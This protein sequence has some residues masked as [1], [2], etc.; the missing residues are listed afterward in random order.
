MIFTAQSNVLLYLWA[1]RP[2]QREHTLNLQTK[3]ELLI[4]R[5]EVQRGP[6]THLHSC[7]DDIH[8]CV[9]KH[10]GST[11]H[12][13]EQSSYHRVNVF[14]GVVA[15]TWKKRRHILLNDTK[16]ILDVWTN[17]ISSRT[18]VPVPQR[19]HD[20][21]ADGLVGALLQYS[22]CEALISPLQTWGGHHC[23]DH[24]H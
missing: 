13:S 2:C 17:V 23:Q 15:L 21:E 12:G 11:S 8:G 24:H 22:G 4:P 3:V 5:V 10:T 1:S 7:F 18:F 14:V 19:C 20:V 16:V 9:S 6:V